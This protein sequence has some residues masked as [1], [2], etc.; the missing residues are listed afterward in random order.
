MLR[1]AH[2]TEKLQ[3]FLW[4]QDNGQSLRLFGCRDHVVKRPLPFERDLVEESESGNGDK[5]RT[6][7]QLPLIDEIYLVGP[8]LLWPQLLR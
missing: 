1:A 2:S 6:R 3:D 4:A 8:D 7:V 5:N